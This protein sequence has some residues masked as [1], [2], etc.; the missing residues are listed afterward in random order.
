MTAITPTSD[1]FSLNA[2]DWPHCG[3]GVD[4]AHD[5]VG[6]RGRQ[7]EPYT[8][9]LAHISDADR[10]AYLAGLQ[11]GADI[12]HRGTHLSQQLLAELL[13]ALMDP[14]ANRPRLGNARFGEAT[15]GDARFS[16][17]V[18]DGDASFVRTAFDG[19][20]VFS[21]AEFRSDAWFGKARFDGNASF[22]WAKL[23]G[24]AN[25]VETEF[26]GN[27]WFDG[28]VFDYAKFI[29][30]VFARNARFLGVVFGGDTWFRKAKFDGDAWFGGAVFGGDAWF[31]EA[32]FER[33][34]VTGQLVCTG[35][36]DLSGATF[37]A[38]VTIEAATA[39]LLCRRTRWASTAALRLRYAVVDLSDAVAEYPVSIA[40][41]SQPFTMLGEDLAEPDLTNA[42]VR[43]ASLRGVDAA[44][45]VLT[46]V[47]LTN[48]LFAGTIH[49]DQLRME[50]LYLLATT[51]SGLRRHG[52]L[53]VRWTPRRTLAEEQHWRASRR[54]AADG[55]TAAPDGAEV[56]EPA[57]LAPVYRQL[58]KAFEDGKHEPGAADFYYGEMEMRRYAHDIPW[59]E[60]ALL[61][62]YWAVSGYG[63]RASRALGWL[64]LAMLTT[65]LV[66]ML[67]GLPKN[68]PKAES[69]GTINGR[70]IMM[71]TDTADAVNPDGPY[72]KRL[73]TERFE[74]SL[75]VVIN[76]VVF[77]SSGQGLTTFGTY[78]EMISRIGEPVLLG[79]AV[80][81][82]RGRVKR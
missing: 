36:L 27:V 22:G 16:G 23:D 62:A 6:C 1:V 29:G 30:A 11:P 81:A 59:G 40:A 72:R 58:R 47:D 49:L 18:F 67:W 14:A 35:T 17:V 5:P 76:S 78:T 12:D 52:R 55:W 15:F 82:V 75:R 43:I 3:R 45:L 61:T 33:A 7:I 38:A 65:M 31:D 79:L 13:T 24:G 54:T 74:K 34:K 4:P 37:G 69:T 21:E 41:R 57:A 42:R 64:L 28:S 80:L 25:F 77:R 44:H 2:P 60:R 73:S 9:C 53:P 63:L 56:L 39:R 51:P 32:V 20:A 8:S 48:C 66:M 50:G 46:D 68:A 19:D 70:S 26:G 71:T 10:S